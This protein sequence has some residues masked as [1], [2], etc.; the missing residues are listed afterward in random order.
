MDR[1]PHL[2]GNGPRILV[3]GA[4]GVL[5]DA[6]VALL[7]PE[8]VS[9]LTHRNPLERPGRMQIRADIAEPRLGLRP[10][11]YRELVASTDLVIH[12][13]ALSHIAARP[14]VVRKVNVEGT[15]RV[16]EFCREAEAEL[17]H[18]GTALRPPGGDDDLA[19]FERFDWNPYL[20]SKQEAEDLVRRSGVRS[21]VLRTSL[22]MGDA[23]SGAIPR[24]QG[25]YALAGLLLRDSFGVLAVPPEAPVDFLPRDLLARY[26][27][28]LAQTGP[29]PEPLFLTAGERAASVRSVVEIILEF[30]RG[31]GLSVPEPRF[32]PTEMIERLVKPVFLPALPEKE[33][34]RFEYVIEYSR[35]LNRIEGLP[36]S[37]PQLSGELALPGIPDPGEVLRHSLAYWAGQQRWIKRHVADEAL[38]AS[39]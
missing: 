3:T 10:R 32:V 5:G 25:L 9:C 6:T 17:C 13:A 16:V 14:E 34:R 8:R 21:T 15:R 24:F 37:L 35:P 36:S 2:D 38:E 30:G 27:V 39:K 31:L 11:E 28:T 20:R 7:P 33:R 26:I 4:A 19:P 23:E 22:I 12:S 29:R 1:S 18:I